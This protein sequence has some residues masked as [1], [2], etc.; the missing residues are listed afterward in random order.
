MDLSSERASARESEGQEPEPAASTRSGKRWKCFP[1]DWRGW[2][3]ET[4]AEADARGLTTADLAGHVKY[5]TVRDFTGGAVTDLD[6][7]LRRSLEGIA[8]RK[9]KPESVAGPPA[10]DP[11]AWA[12][13]AEHRDF[14]KER[15]LPLRRAADAYRAARMP[16]K[17][18]STLRANEDFMRR[19]RWWADNGGEFPATGKLPRVEASGEARKAVGA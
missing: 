11:Y 15:R 3:L 4:L 14:A 10:A 6:G 5:W 7:E 18:G 13:T 16:D 19:L 8:E 1:P 17:A 2:S 12:P 9:R